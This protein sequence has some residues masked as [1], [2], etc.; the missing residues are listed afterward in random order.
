MTQEPNILLVEPKTRTSYP[1]L[2]LMKIATYHKMRGDV[3]KFV[4]GKDRAQR[5][6]YWDR[7]YITSVFTYDF[8]TLIDTIQ[9]YREDNFENAS[10]IMVGGISATLLAKQLAERTGLTPH[11]GLLDTPDPELEEAAVSN[12]ELAYLLQ[13]DGG[14]CIDNLPPDYGIFDGVTTRYAKIVDNSFFFFATKGCPNKCSFC[15]VQRLEPV[16]RDYIPLKPRIDYIRQ[17]WGDRPGLLLLDNNIAASDSYERII[18]EIK[19]CGFGRGEK[20]ATFSNGRTVYKLRHVDFNQGVDLRLMTRPKMKK[21]AEIAIKPLRLAFDDAALSAEYEEKAR[22]AI[23]CGIDNISNYMLF[24]FKD[25]PADLYRR[26]AVNLRILADHPSAKIFSFPMRYSPINRTD[27]TFLGKHWM[28]RQVRAIQLILNA[29]HGI[30]SH[31]QPFFHHAFGEDE[32]HFHRLLLYP[33]H[34]I[35][36]REFY[37]KNENNGLNISEWERQYGK[38]SSG[39]KD[40]LL[41]I[42]QTCPLKSPPKTASMK[43]NDILQHYAGENSKTLERSN[44]Y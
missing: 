22:M 25:S 41:N 24:N 3:V 28:R 33:Q 31:K 15:A 7:I 17:R 18:D 20:M 38:L 37:E 40:E 21:M 44:E 27:R 29:T 30:V 2:G 5:E 39:S 26:F 6:K 34:Y 23:D 32:E 1:P 11:L 4:V 35:I 14:P 9:F 16:Y 19:D 13:C 36:N 12:A 42:L 8:E 43:L 10:R